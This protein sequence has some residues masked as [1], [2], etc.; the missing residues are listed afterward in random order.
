[1]GDLAG[2]PMNEELPRS[3]TSMM[4]NSC[5]HVPDPAFSWKQSFPIPHR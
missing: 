2:S 5:E 3:I 4:V 1:M